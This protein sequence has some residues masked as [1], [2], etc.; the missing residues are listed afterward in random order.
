MSDS[1]NEIRRKEASIVVAGSEAKSL[2]FGILSAIVALITFIA[3]I[4]FIL[5]LVF[6]VIFAFIALI[7]FLR[8]HLLMEAKEVVDKG[9]VT[10]GCSY[11]HNKLS[12]ESP[13]EWVFKDD[14][15]NA[16][17]QFAFKT[18][19]NIFESVTRSS[20]FRL[21]KL[22]VKHDEIIVFW[23][24]KKNIFFYPRLKVYAYFP[25][26]TNFSKLKINKKYKSVF[27][28]ED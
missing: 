20:S 13:G 6:T 19:S 16:D 9:K 23:M 5:W 24:Y 4:N 8:F 14:E 10:N 17:V 25:Q 26:F 22:I 1:A 7:F 15:K 18:S 11:Y 3:G 28:D 12:G 21:P 2:I 27:K